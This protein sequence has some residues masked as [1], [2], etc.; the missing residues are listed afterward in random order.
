MRINEQPSRLLWLDWLHIL[1]SALVCFLVLAVLT[2]ALYPLLVTGVAQTLFPD[3]AAG[4]LVK[5]HGETVGSRLIGQD[6]STTPFF[7]SRPSATFPPYNAQASEATNY[8]PAHPKL[9]ASAIDR[10]ITWHK[11]V[12]EDGPVPN[13]LVT[14][15]ASGLDPHISV[16]AARYQIAM[17]ARQTGI[18]PERLEEL[19]TQHETRG[20]FGRHHYVN[21]LLLNLNVQQEMLA[22]EQALAKEP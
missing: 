11:W 3:R 21:V 19:I 7:R 22:H 9:I 4:S 16:R 8:G 5:L 1:K 18:A 13:E 12:R 10:I 2:G 15:S 20:F 17:V 14:S 6:F